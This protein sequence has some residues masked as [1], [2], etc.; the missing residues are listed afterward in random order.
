MIVLGIETSCDETAVALISMGSPLAPW[1]ILSETI[2]SQTDL[3]EKY[4][5]VVP[6]LASR[7]HLKNLPLLCEETLRAGNLSMADV[8]CIGVTRGPGL[9]GCLL[10]GLAFARGLASTRNIALIGVNHIEG[11]MLAPLLDNPA[12]TFPFL[13]LVVSGGHTELHL[14]Y[15]I[16]RYEVLARTSDDAAGEAFDKS[17]NLLGFQYPGG[18]KLA[19]LADTWGLT[20]IRPDLVRPDL[21]H[22]DL[23]LPKVM[24]DRRDFS[25]SGLK[26]AIALLVARQHRDGVLNEE[27]RVQL[28]FSIQEAIVEALVSKVQHAIDRTGVRRVVVTGGVSANRRLRQRVSELRS[29]GQKVEAYFPLMQHCTDNAAMIAFVAGLRAALGERIKEGESVLSRWPVEDVAT[30]SL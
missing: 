16:G 19:A 12:L 24:R 28:A 10:I 23:K 22:P 21:V 30:G 29:A 27:L 7:E 14:A 2:S 5:G 18:A 6:E 20:A 8:D 1:K 17:A 9:K 11:H 26:T 15:D 4:G 25:F 13:A 3:H